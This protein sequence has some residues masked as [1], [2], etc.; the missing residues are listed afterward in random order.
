[1]TPSLQQNFVG[2]PKTSAPP[3][4][5][6][7]INRSGKVVLVYNI[8]PL[9]FSN[10]SRTVF[11]VFL[12]MGTCGPKSR[13]RVFA[14]VATTPPFLYTLAAIFPQ[15]IQPGYWVFY[16]LSYDFQ[17]NTGPTKPLCSK[18][19]PSPPV[20][21]ESLTGTILN[22]LRCR[23]R[24]N[25]PTSGTVNSLSM[26]TSWLREPAP[27]GGVTFGSSHPTSLKATYSLT[28]PVSEAVPLLP[29]Q[30]W[31]IADSQNF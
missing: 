30:S 6:T 16:L 11:P 8:F 24:H 3:K 22:S 18:S 1:M 27:P 10:V 15:S 21:F 9:W 31:H 29:G 2:A 7:S 26:R 17:G 25:M 20:L 19:F 4:P 13:S 23:K 5:K 28:L 12:L 14:L